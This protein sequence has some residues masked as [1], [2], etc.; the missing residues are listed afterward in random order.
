MTPPSKLRVLM[1][2]DAVGSV[3]SYASELARALC[4]GGTRVLLVI[5][6]PPP[7]PDS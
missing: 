2:T 5:M 7:Q 3:W 6:G 1:T 4:Q